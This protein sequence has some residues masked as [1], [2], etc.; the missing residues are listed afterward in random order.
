MLTPLAPT[1]YERGVRVAPV[2]P[3]ATRFNKVDEY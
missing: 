1:T 3:S 2:N